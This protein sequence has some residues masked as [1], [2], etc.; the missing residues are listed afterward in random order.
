MAAKSADEVIMEL[1]AKVKTKQAEIKKLGKPSWK[2]SCTIGFTEALSDRVN[3]QT[4]TDREKLVA[5]YSRLL[6]LEDNWDVANKDLGL[7]IEPTH[8]GKPV[9]DWKADVATRVGQLTIE[10]KKQELK[11]LEERLDKIV[12]P[13]KRREMELEAIQAE[14]AE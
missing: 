4:V 7:D 9:A 2:T 10:T 5:I 6:T 8:Q 13:E 12:S 3:I 1:L 14:L 11:K